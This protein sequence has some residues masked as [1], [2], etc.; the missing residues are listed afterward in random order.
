MMK[1]MIMMITDFSGKKKKK[2]KKKKNVIKKWARIQGM[3]KL[4]NPNTLII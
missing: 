4:R 2:K 1:L 3:G